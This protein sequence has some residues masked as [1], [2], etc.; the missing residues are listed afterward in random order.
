[1]LLAPDP[2]SLILR[3]MNDAKKE[4]QARSKAEWKAFCEQC[5]ADYKFNPEKD[6]ELTAARLLAQ[7]KGEWAKVWTRFGD[8]PQRYTGG[9]S[10]LERIDPPK[11]LELGSDPESWPKINDKL[12]A[13]ISE[14]L[15]KLG[16][17]R[18]DEAVP[19]VKELE[20]KYGHQR[21][22]VWREIGRSQFAVA[23]GDL[24]ELGNL[25]EKP[26]AAGAADEMGEL[27]AQTGWKVDAFVLKALD[28]CKT[29]EHEE[30]IHSAVRTLYLTWL[31]QSARNLQ[32]L[33]KH[34][35]ACMRPRLGAVEASDGRV[36]I[37]ADGLR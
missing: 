9:V 13:E 37:F 6:G 2:A 26:L 30:P 3:W 1:R 20:G 24:N 32:S 25:V 16:T 14:S 33:K 4:K 29:V 7:R 34:S 28:C 27:Y 5:E 11:Q 19:R 31:D 23:L 21:N 18:P 17:L 8:A 12:E 15:K 22:W 10:L 35:P 36:I